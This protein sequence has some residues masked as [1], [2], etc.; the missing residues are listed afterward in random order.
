MESLSLV[1]SGLT[2]V[3]LLALAF[4]VMRMAKGWGAKDRGLD[5]VHQQMDAL[6]DQVNNQLAAVNT[7]LIQTTGQIGER[8]EGATKM[9]G[10]VHKGLGELGQASKQM[11]DVGKDIA[12]LHDILK[13]PKMRG[14]LGEVFL[15]EIL[16]QLVP[17]A[18]DFQYRFKTGETVD[19]IIRIGDKVVPIDAKFPVENFR[20]MIESA[21]ESDRLRYRRTFATDVKKHID[22]I[23]GKYLRPE[24]GTY[25][26]ALMYIPAEN[27]YYELIVRHGPDEKSIADYATGKRVIP[28]SP[29]TIY[30]Y[31][32]V[33]ILGLKGLQVEE[34]AEKILG[35]LARLKGDFSKF[36]SDFEVLGGHLNNAAKKYEEADRKLARFDDKLALTDDIEGEKGEITSSAQDH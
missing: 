24:E 13:P 22:A 10:A 5:R 14:V 7:Q 2:L 32:Q 35:H 4:I 12:S 15:K 3:V 19:A 18:C 25:D 34:N 29:N 16:E 20:K 11:Y 33:I 1:I 27:V 28:V 23:H 9:V 6:R 8:L 30:A 21:E 31:L 26:F 36:T 17:T